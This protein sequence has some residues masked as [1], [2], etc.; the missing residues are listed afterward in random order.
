MR[1][2]IYF[3]NI[4]NPF[5]GGTERAAHNL[6]SCLHLKGHDI[7]TLAKYRSEERCD[8]PIFYLPSQDI[9]S[10]DNI[11]FIEKVINENQI[12]VLINEGGNTS[13]VQLFN[14]L[15]LKTKVQIITCLHFAAFQGFGKEYYA[16]FD[17]RSLTSVF[18]ILKKPINQ[19]N[20]LKLFRSNY[21]T[22]LE[23]SD[24]F[25]VLNEEFKKQIVFLTGLKEY[26][27]K[28]KII[29]N[30]NILTPE[31]FIKK[32]ENIIL[33]VGRLQYETKRVDRLI[34]AW[35]IVENNLNNWD[36][37]IL[38]DGPDRRWYES[39][40][41]KMNLKRVH[42]EGRKDP[43]AYYKK[44]KIITLVSTHESFGMTLVE[45]MAFGCVPVVFNSYPT[46]S[47]ILDDGE[48]GVL[49]EPFKL[50]DYAEALRGLCMAPHKLSKLSELAIVKAYQYTGDQILPLWDK[51]IQGKWS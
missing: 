34:K 28:I 32:K 46:A 23:Y 9:I 40:S 27:S 8:F 47:E 20:A 38:G 26:S 33:Y 13:D 44:A 22:I 1:F 4:I 2:L 41:D 10:N 6:V 15:K 19:Y 35:S 31:N 51:L 3:E 7:I 21:T 49:V 48:C 18:K 36:L 42:F 16:D 11:E 29:P 12:D 30:I 37:V 17:L 25:I 50:A 24:E 5:K 45:G 43:T 14:H 39:L